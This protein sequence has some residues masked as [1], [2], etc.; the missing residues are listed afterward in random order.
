VAGVYQF[1]FYTIVYSNISNAA[2]SFR[3]NGGYPT[4]G[5]NVHFS[6]SA[7]GVWSNVVYTTSLYLD[8]GDFVCLQNVGGYT[9]Y[10]GGQWSSFSGFL[11][12]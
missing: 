9:Q 7:S 10:H 5:F 3:K 1:N 8:A 4:S 6:P 2:I 11:V 12:G